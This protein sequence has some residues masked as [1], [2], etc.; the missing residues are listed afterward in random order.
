MEPDS[1]LR[2]DWH[3]SDQPA[4]KIAL[5][6]AARMVRGFIIKWISSIRT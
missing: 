2:I 4:R 6:E 5:T 1:L 3:P